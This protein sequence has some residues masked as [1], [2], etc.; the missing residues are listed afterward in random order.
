MKKIIVP[1]LFLTLLVPMA[2]DSG[3]GGKT[4]KTNE[5]FIKYLADKYPAAYCDYLQRCPDT[6]MPAG[7]TSSQCRVLFGQFFMMEMSMSMG[8]VLDNGATYDVKKVDECLAALKN[9]E[10]GKDPDSVAACRQ[11]ISGTLA[12]GQPCSDDAQCTS[13]YCD[14]EQACPGVCAATLAANS[15]CNYT[16]Q[17]NPGLVCDYVDN[18]CKTNATSLNPGDECEWYCGYGME[19]VY[20]Y[21][22]WDATCQEW[23]QANESCEPHDGPECAPGLGCDEGSGQCK[24]VTIVNEGGTCDDQVKVCDFTKQLYCV[25]GSCVRIPGAG[26]DCLMGEAC[27]HGTYCGTDTKCHA[28]KAVGESCTANAECQSRKCSTGNECVYEPCPTYE[29]D[30]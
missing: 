25:Q 10:C 2:C 12:N 23:L 30:K 5:D 18:K 9:L 29:Y 3:S 17:C 11:A 19:C 8:W 27:W 26:E 14:T 21:E 7:L 20:D 1:L 22:T 6:D 28:L 13:G 24:P 15:D 16:R 4:I